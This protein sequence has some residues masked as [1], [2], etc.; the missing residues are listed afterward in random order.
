MKINMNKENYDS[1]NTSSVSLAGVAIKGRNINGDVSMISPSLQTSLCKLINEENNN[2]H[3]EQD[4]NDTNLDDRDRPD[5]LR[6]EKLVYGYRNKQ[7]I[8]KQQ[9]S[10]FSDIAQE[11]GKQNTARE[12]DKEIQEGKCTSFQSQKSCDSIIEHANN[13]NYQDPCERTLHKIVTNTLKYYQINENYDSDIIMKLYGDYG[14][15]QYAS[16]ATNDSDPRMLNSIIDFGEYPIAKVFNKKK[17]VKKEQFDDIEKQQRGP[18]ENNPNKI[19]KQ[20]YSD[21]T[22][23]PPRPSK[24]VDILTYS[25]CSPNF[26]IREDQIPEETI[27]LTNADRQEFIL[28]IAQVN[29]IL[30]PLRGKVAAYDRFIL[31]Y[32]VFGMIITGGL[33]AI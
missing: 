19:K 9:T 20:R 1:N 6:L 5:V 24:Y 14:L 29:R 2:Y 18:S 13:V 28:T 30:K 15:L 12:E 17:K 4:N 25:E 16:L 8:I 21:L 7:Y 33:S 27:S 11:S 23:L 10:D 32:L 3:D 26:E 31:L 22:F